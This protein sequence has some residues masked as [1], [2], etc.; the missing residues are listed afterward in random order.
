MSTIHLLF[1]VFLL[2]ATFRGKKGKILPDNYH[3]H[4]LIQEKTL[5]RQ[6]NFPTIT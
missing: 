2:L 5:D 6:N 4:F 1:I 3:L